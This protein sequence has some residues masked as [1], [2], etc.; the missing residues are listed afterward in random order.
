MR[1]RRKLFDDD[2]T[3]ILLA[4]L[5]VLGLRKKHRQQVRRA[6]EWMMPALVGPR[7]TKNIEVIVRFVPNLGGYV[8][9]CEWIDD[10]ISPRQFL[11]RISLRQP[12]KQ[13]LLTLAH[14]LTHVKQFVTNQ[15]FDYASSTELS[16]WHRRVINIAQYS[17]RE[18]PWEKD[19]YA[20]QG[21]LLRAYT[22]WMKHHEKG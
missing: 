6:I 8:G 13:Q 12:R 5:S 4:R 9:D 18:L 19:A 3:P 15:L 16:R 1:K 2:A 14:E 17:Y 20:T 11:I 10:N 22:Q 21:P 7:M